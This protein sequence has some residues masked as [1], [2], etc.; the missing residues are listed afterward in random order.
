MSRPEDRASGKDR[1]EPPERPTVT[2]RNLSCGYRRKAILTGVDL[3]VRTGEVLCLLGPNG[4]GKTTLF[5]TLLGSLPPVEGRVEISSRERS[6][7]SRREMARH[8]AYVPQLHEPPFAFSVFDVALTGCVSR[9][10]L[11]DSPSRRDRRRTEEVLDRLGIAHL[12]A[13][14]FTELSGG[15][16][17]MALIARA[18]V[19]DGRILVM[20][21]PAAALDLRNQAT[22]LRCVRDLADERHGVL[23]TSHNPDHAFLVATRAVLITRDREILSGPVDEVLT[24][25]NL[26]AAYGTRV[27]VLEATSP[28]GEAMRTCLP[29][30]YLV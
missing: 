11:L 29:S 21:E 22:V 10:G 13:R 20:D 23:M 30:L 4:V 17:Q 27:R 6:R 18:L 7:L 26:R 2:A 28:D 15:E 9:L 14:P 16:Q 24:E 3:E 19:Q 5:R 12:S 1:P 25:D 8:I